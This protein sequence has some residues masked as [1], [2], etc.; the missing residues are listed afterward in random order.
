MNHLC[1]KQF[2]PPALK[3]CPY[4]VLYGTLNSSGRKYCYKYL[5]PKRDYGCVKQ[6]LKPF[7]HEG[8]NIFLEQDNLSISISPDRDEI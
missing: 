4:F 7:C 8:D 2:I 6:R 3:M 1:S 5:I